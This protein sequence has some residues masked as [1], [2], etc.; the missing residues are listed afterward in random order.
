MIHRH[1]LLLSQYRT[2][3]MNH[4]MCRN[5]VQKVHRTINRN[6]ATNLQIRRVDRMDR[7]MA[8]TIKLIKII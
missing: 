2:A 7:R 6:E 5:K 3:K 1:Q 8:T 4:P